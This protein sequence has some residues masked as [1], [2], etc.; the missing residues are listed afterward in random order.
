MKHDK[1]FFPQHLF[2]RHPEFQCWSLAGG[3]QGGAFDIRIF[4][5]RAARGTDSIDMGGRGV[6]FRFLLIL[7][8]LLSYASLLATPTVCEISSITSS[9]DGFAVPAFFTHFFLVSSLRLTSFR[10]SF[11]AR[12][13]SSL[14]LPRS[15]R[16]TE[17]LSAAITFAALLPAG[18]R[19]ARVRAW[20]HSL[21]VAL[22]LVAFQPTLAL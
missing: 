21:A 20:R 4:R 11:S 8:L 9:C 22:A 16:R 6:P 19:Y 14:H 2:P 15:V 12:L 3:P 7:A 13:F 17:T 5:K 18:R 1:I 10:L